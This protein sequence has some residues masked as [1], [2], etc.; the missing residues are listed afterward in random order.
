M[1]SSDLYESD[2]YAWANEQAR[3]IREERM[4]EADLRNIAEEIESMGRGEKRELVSRLDVLLLQLLKWKYQPVRPGNSWRL[5][6]QNARDA[7][8]TIWLITQLASPGWPRRKIPHTAVP[9]LKHPS[10]LAS[11]WPPY[12]S[13][14]RGRLNR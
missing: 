4:A 5:S 3:L 13:P 10:R 6:I 11:T 14:V 2:F 9:A 1:S 12:P 7:L 8:A